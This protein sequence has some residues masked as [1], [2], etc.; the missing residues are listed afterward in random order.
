[1]TQGVRCLNSGTVHDTRCECLNGGTVYDTRCEV[2]ERWHSSGHNVTSTI[3]PAPLPQGVQEEAVVIV[4]PVAA[5]V[6]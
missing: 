3:T 6:L 1:M 5:A 4:V 2:S